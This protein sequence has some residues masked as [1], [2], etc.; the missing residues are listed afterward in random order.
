[1]S[2]RRRATTQPPIPNGSSKNKVVVEVSESDTETVACNQ[3]KKQKKTAK[4]SHEG[5]DEASET[6]PVDDSW[7]D[8]WDFTVHRCNTC[9]RPFT[10]KQRLKQHQKNDKCASLPYQSADAEEPAIEVDELVEL[11]FDCDLVL[12]NI[13]PTSHS[14]PK[15]RTYGF[16]V[17]S[18]ALCISS[19]VFTELFGST[20]SSKTAIDVRKAAFSRA[21]P[22]KYKLEQ[23]DHKGLLIALSILHNKNSNVPEN[24]DCS[25]LAS[26]ALFVNRYKTHEA[27]STWARR[28]KDKHTGSILKADYASWLYIAYVFGYKDLYSEMSRLLSLCTAWDPLS[29]TLTMPKPVSKSKSSKGALL[30]LHPHL[31]KEVTDGLIRLREK[32]VKPIR[33]FLLRE[34]TKRYD[35]SVQHCKASEDTHKIACDSYRLGQFLRTVKIYQ[36][37]E[38][39]ATW[40]KSV[41]AICKELD[42]ISFETFYFMTPFKTKMRDCPNCADYMDGDADEFDEGPAGHTCVLSCDRSLLSGADL[43]QRCDWLPALKDICKKALQEMNSLTL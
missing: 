11:A 43:H 10:T 2:T 3:R 4:P 8:A 9:S 5:D 22:V 12:V 38:G 29:K 20:S 6:L 24:V 19:S 37:E 25:T 35:F 15:A 36:L 27:L 40:D 14:T 26:I 31:P 18:R 16:K 33:S 28:W 32:R 41:E 23:I 1:M 7:L 13:V 42:A 21:P 17:S 30:P 39:S 34:T